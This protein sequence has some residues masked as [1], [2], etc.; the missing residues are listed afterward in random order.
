MLDVWLRL[1]WDYAVELS[2]V[3]AKLARDERRRTVSEAP[4]RLNREQALLL[5]DRG[6]YLINRQVNG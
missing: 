5:Q 4:R 3:G 6:D 1:L 2:L